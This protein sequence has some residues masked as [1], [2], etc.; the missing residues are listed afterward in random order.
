M[1]SKTCGRWIQRR[2]GRLAEHY[3]SRKSFK[4]L[5][6]FMPLLQ[7]SAKDVKLHPGRPT[8][9]R[10]LGTQNEAGVATRKHRSR[11]CVC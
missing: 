8:G 5:K 9:T 3:I 4:Y 2:H 1:H 7:V 11:R 10:V 6:T